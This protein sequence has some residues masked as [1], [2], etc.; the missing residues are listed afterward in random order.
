M[1][2]WISISMFWILCM[3]EINRCSFHLVQNW[4]YFDIAGSV[5]VQI[6]RQD[7]VSCADGGLRKQNIY[8]VPNTG[9]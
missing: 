6:R 1:M 8:N 3:Y 9:T 4:L 7:G 5:E 2:E